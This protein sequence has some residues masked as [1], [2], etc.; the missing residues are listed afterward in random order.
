MEWRWEIFNSV[1]V[2]VDCDEMNVAYNIHKIKSNEKNIQKIIKEQCKYTYV[3]VEWIYFI[4]NNNSSVAFLSY[5]F[6]FQLYN[7]IQILISWQSL[8]VDVKDL[9]GLDSSFS[10]IGSS[11]NISTK[12][13]LDI[14]IT[15]WRTSKLCRQIY[16]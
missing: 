5:C 6:N 11:I 3:Y 16:I 12:E 10:S 7:C 8:R 1:V 15:I 4:T 2:R 14:S 9:S 13:Y